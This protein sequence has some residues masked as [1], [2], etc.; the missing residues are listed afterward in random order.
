MRILFIHPNSPDYLCASLFHGLREIYGANCVDLPRYDCM[1]A[2]IRQGVLNKIRGHGFSLY[3][4]LEDMP[5]LEEERFFIWQK[6]IATFDLYIIADIWNNWRMLDQ[7]LEHVEP[8]RILILDGD[9]TNR[10]FPWNNWRTSWSSILGKKKLLK[11]CL[12]YAK[13]EIPAQWREAI[14]PSI[15]LLPNRMYRSL[16]PDNLLPIS[17]GIPASKISYVTAR[18][19]TQRFTTHIVDEDIRKAFRQHQNTGSYVF[20]N[21]QDY[22]ADIQKS[23]YGITTKRGGWDCLRHYEFAANGAVL[24]FKE[25]DEKP[26]LSAPHGLNATNSICY[27]NFE[28][29]DAKLQAIT[30]VEY[31]KF[32]LNSYR[33]IEQ[34]TTKAVA[35]RVMSSIQAM[36]QAT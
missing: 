21:E 2:P 33:W 1:Y 16:L 25:L 19:K 20:S 12:G 24:C 14:G 4:L 5:K 30:E 35:N 26:V 13:R 29:L 17:F 22:Y 10:V 6:N 7:L 3:G 11:N 31:E 18:Q 8:Q 34:Y 27:K 23:M 15:Q 36:I 28:D 9:D 32:L